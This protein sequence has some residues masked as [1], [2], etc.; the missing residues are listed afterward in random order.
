MYHRALTFCFFQDLQDKVLNLKPFFKILL[1]LFYTC[2]FF[3]ANLCDKVRWVGSFRN[4][5]RQTVKVEE[6]QSM[7][8]EIQMVIL[9]C[10]MQ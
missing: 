7:Y 8:Q 2:I 9:S 5:E 3:Q 6:C 1:L 4:V 10:P